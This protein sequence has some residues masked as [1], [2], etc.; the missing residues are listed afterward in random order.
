[1]Q[2]QIVCDK[3]GMGFKYKYQGNIHNQKHHRMPKFQCNQCHYQWTTEKLVK[4]HIE[5][6]HEDK[7]YK[8]DEC[9][10]EAKYKYQ[11]LAHKQ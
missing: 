6:V 3:C 1:M 5:S 4:S 10:Y 11:I 8:C 9:E 2:N 7:T